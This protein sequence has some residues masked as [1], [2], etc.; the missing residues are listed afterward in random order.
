MAIKEVNLD[1]IPAQDSVLYINKSGISFSAKFVK[2]EKL[3]EAK[4][5]K[6]YANDEDPYYLGFKFKNEL[7]EPNTL[8]LVASGRTRGGGAGFTIK[9]GE[10]INKN[11]I[12]KNV[13]RMTSKQ[14]RTFEIFFDKK[15]SIY[16]ILLRPNFEII[17]NYSDKNTI[18]DA[19]KGIYRYRNKEGQI[20]YI[21]KGGIKTRVN[22][23]Q[24]RDWGIA[25]IEYSILLDDELSFYWENYYLDR[26]L[27]ING[28]KPPFNVIMG[29]SE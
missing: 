22:S 27:S 23:P 10:L 7:D 24:R 2:K 3:Q 20:I 28:S 9:A 18:P 16:S 26:Y 8:S 13:Q 29:K 19:F 5:I 6:F 12:L 4:G 11:P 14:D 17:V 21:G 15:E 25:K 1:R